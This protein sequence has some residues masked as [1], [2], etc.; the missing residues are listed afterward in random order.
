MAERMAVQLVALKADLRVDSMVVQSVG[1]LDAD[2]VGL[3][4]F[5]MAERMAD[6]PVG[7]MVV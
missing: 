5:E 6:V 1:E 4:G 3:L 2:L 7:W